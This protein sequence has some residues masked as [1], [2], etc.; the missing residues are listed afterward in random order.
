[1]D[2][3][4]W[5]L[6]ASVVYSHGS[7]ADWWVKGFKDPQI[8]GWPQQ[9]LSHFTVLLG[10][11]TLSRFKNPACNYFFWTQGLCLEVHCLEVKEFCHFSC[12]G[13]DREPEV[14]W[15][16]L[17]SKSFIVDLRTTVFTKVQ[18]LPRPPCLEELTAIT[19]SWLHYSFIQVMF[20]TGKRIHIKLSKRRDTRGR[21][22]RE[23]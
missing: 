7:Y 9:W 1:M 4:Q 13:W 5:W 3:E 15:M 21:I 23:S 2:L 14:L 17:I 11:P 6:N 19:E 18:C 12:S 16:K 10:S 8:K 20:N 22:L